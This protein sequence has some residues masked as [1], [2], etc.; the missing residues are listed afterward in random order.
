MGGSNFEQLIEEVLNQKR[1]ME[2]LLAENH[3]LR[4]QL[5]DLRDGRV[6]FLEIQGQR[7]LLAGEIA[8][9]SQQ[10]ERSS[11]EVF[12]AEQATTMMPIS[13]AVV[14]TG[15]SPETPAPGTDEIE[16]L[17]YSLNREEVAAPSRPSSFLEQMLVDEFAAAATSPMAVWQG[18]K[19]RKLAT[20]D[21]EE[22]AAL[23]KQL[24]GS[25]LL[26]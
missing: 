20:I 23:R 17:S 4:R 10:V 2:D 7:F 14:V 19:T 16:Q 8:A 21:E 22:K 1:L 11:Q 24:I 12:V 3:E 26:E 5:A 18:S 25:F 13:G 6:I 9:D 15:A